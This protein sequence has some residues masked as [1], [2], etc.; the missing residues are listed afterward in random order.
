MKI[1]LV[2]VCLAYLLLLPGCQNDSDYLVGSYDVLLTVTSS[3]CAAENFALPA[4]TLLPTGGLPGQ[5][6]RLRWDFRRIAV[7]G[8]GADKIVLA[9]QPPTSPAQ[10]LAL[11][12]TLDHGVLRV[13]GQQ[14][15]RVPPCETDRFIL[16]TGMLDNQAIAG[17][18]HIVLS[19]PA[20]SE[21]CPA[22]TLPRSPCEVVEAFSGA[23]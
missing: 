16:L 18:I 7:T 3:T 22:V 13:D 20:D 15:I 14:N 12:G 21:R 9:I 6:R 2:G 1:M 8:A 23:R 5:P 10:V 11:S 19:N 17:E 4:E